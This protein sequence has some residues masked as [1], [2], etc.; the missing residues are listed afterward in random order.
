MKCD[1]ETQEGYESL[2]DNGDMFV[3]ETMICQT[4][5]RCFAAQC[6]KDLGMG[7]PKTWAPTIV[8]V[9]TFCAGEQESTNFQYIGERR[10]RCGF[11][12]NHKSHTLRETFT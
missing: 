9:S 10:K 6:A 8:R 7:I 12:Q 4:I 3:S 2:P 1:R 5:F 11:P